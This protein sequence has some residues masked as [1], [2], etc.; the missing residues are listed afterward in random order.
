MII[1]SIFGNF[2]VLALSRT[3]RDKKYW[4]CQCVCG[5]IKEIRGD[6]IAKYIN[7]PCKCDMIDLVGKTFG[8]LTVI[9]KAYSA[10]YGFH[11][12][13]KCLCG[14]EKIV[15]GSHLKQGATKSCGCQQGGNGGIIKHGY[16]SGRD[17][18]PLPEYTA[19][20]A[21]MAR[22]DNPKTLHYR[23]YGGRGITYCERWRKFEN[24]L[25][26]MGNRPS[27]EHSLDRYPN[28]NGNYEPTNC[29]WA[30]SPQQNRNTSRNVYIEFAGKS[31]VL[32][33]WANELGTD[34]SNI[35]RKLKNGQSFGQI[36]QH[37]KCSRFKKEDEFYKK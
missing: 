24:F 13:C 35:T 16:A 3:A 4:E 5:M 17:K 20:L 2:T 14:V 7:K 22:C 15:R 9:E 18:K 26:D 8:S 27:D 36:Y 34:P 23:L 19:W 12:K 32:E 33:D 25:A 6:R 37:H 29:R 28:K 30:T 31:M 1:G 11:W 10:K 21:M